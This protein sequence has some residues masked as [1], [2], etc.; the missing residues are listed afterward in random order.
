MAIICHFYAIMIAKCGVISL[1]E[2][3]N[4]LQEDIQK[5][6]TGFVELLTKLVK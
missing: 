5:N 6:P 1:T 2:E 4:K 3:A